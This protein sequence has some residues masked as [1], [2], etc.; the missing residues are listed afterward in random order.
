MI[1]REFAELID[2]ARQRGDNWEGRC[3]AH[4]DSRPS[5]SWRDGDSG[6][7]LH[8]H[9]GCRVEEICAVLKIPVSALF[10]ESTDRRPARDT[11]P[12]LYTYD[13]VDQAGH[14]RFQVV[15][16][17]AKRFWQRRPGPDG[18]WVNG[19]G[20]TPRVLYHLDRLQGEPQVAVAEGEKDADRL[21]ALGIPATTNPMGAGKWTEAYTRQLVDA[22][23][24]AVVLFSDNDTLGQQHVE[25]IARSVTAAGLE[26][27]RVQLPGL[28]PVQPKHGEDVS[29]WLDAG[30]SLE[31]LHAAIAA[32]TPAATPADAPGRPRSATEKTRSPRADE[33]STPPPRVQFRS[34][35]AL[36]ATP[37]TYAVEDML[38][39]GMLGALG[40]KDGMGKTLLGMEIIKC[41][42]TGEK[43]FGRFAVQP[44]TV[45]AMFLDDPEFLVR[46]RLDGMGILDHPALHVATENDVDMTDPKAMLTALIALLKA[47][48]PRPTFIFVDALYLFIPSGGASDQGNSAGAMAPVIEAFNQVTRETGSA[49][50]LVAHDNKA[51]S[52]IAGSYAIRAGCKS[53]L[54]MLLPPAIAKK[55]AKGDEEARETSERM[56]Q[57]NKLKTGRPGS[58][59]LRLEGPGQWTFHGGAA[60]YRRSTLPARVLESLWGRGPSTADEIAKDIKA[61]KVEVIQA[62]GRLYLADQIT[63]DER[64]RED[65]KPGR[66]ATIYGPKAP[67]GG[68]GNDRTK[69]R[70]RENIGNDRSEDRKPKNQ[71]DT[72]TDTLSFPSDPSTRAREAIVPAIPAEGGESPS[73]PESPDDLTSDCF[74]Q[75]SDCYDPPEPQPVTAPTP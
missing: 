49:L 10:R 20:E 69:E 37:I 36:D 9:R 12:I 25:A 8:C 15:R 18:A 74:D 39:A 32:A 67:V 70:E 59:Y 24:R 1:A 26:A 21:W 45:Y 3:P 30:H 23:V 64:A 65:G 22:G 17:A 27:G 29:D 71:R 57:L 73:F 33:V 52:D 54:R 41:V 43:L 35:S 40:G 55:V 19:L 14:L 61:R 16:T 66:G 75:T 68:N 72:T 48:E 13:Y 47:A 6:L 46:E 53:I 62:C 5:L 2:H 51:G 56:L 7:V 31:E 28:P 11:D 63:K 34:G 60:A 4:Q 42:L 50:L 38:P 44:G 58:W